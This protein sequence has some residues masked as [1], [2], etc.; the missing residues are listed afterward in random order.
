M[1]NREYLL[2]NAGVPIR[3]ILTGD[4]SLIPEMLENFEV[5]EW[6][7]R[8]REWAEC[9]K[10]HD[11]HGSDDRRYINI[12]GKC[13]IL[14]LNKDIPE[15]D[16]IM[17]FYLDRL[18]TQIEKR[19]DDKRTFGRIYNYRD[20]ETL[21]ACYLP[22]M[23]YYDDTAVRYIADKRIDYVYNFTKEKRYDI[24]RDGAYYPGARKEWLVYMVDPALYSDGNISLA[25][26]YD[27]ILYAGMYNHV[28]DERKRKIDTI[29]EWIYDDRYDDIP[30]GYNYYAPDDARYKSKSIN[31][32]L[33]L[34]PLPDEPHIKGSK[35]G[36]LFTCFL[37]SHFKAT[38]ESKW[39]SKAM[40]FLS[41]Y[42]TAD[43]RYKLPP[44]L[45]LDKPD[46]RAHVGHLNVGE[47]K[48][49]KN[50]A[51]ILSTYCVERIL[52]NF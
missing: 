1:S 23:G 33:G 4:K 8:L 12:I 21:T 48:R 40:N 18:H 26:Y 13:C 39:W 3:Y 27:Y 41:L 14:G 32:K 42:Q 50:Y 30:G 15:F 51:E 49:K 47:N 38:Y 31:G 37:L 43:G 36:F 7:R 17:K 44:D 16:G 11:I 22:F 35:P 24:Y 2:G 28:D 34:T 9:N 52:N 45:I 6:M 19:L 5:M 46:T 25:E 20:Y 10:W 29:V